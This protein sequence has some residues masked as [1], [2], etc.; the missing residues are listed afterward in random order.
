MRVLI[1]VLLSATLWG[2]GQGGTDSS[3][4]SAVEGDRGGPGATSAPTPAGVEEAFDAT[5]DHIAE[6]GADEAHSSATDYVRRIAQERLYQIEAAR[7]AM[8]GNVSSEMKAFAKQA[9]AVNM[10]AL[11]ALREA[12]RAGGHIGLVPGTVNREQARQLDEL[13]AAKGGRLQQLYRRLAESTLEGMV[14]RHDQ[15]KKNGKVSSLVKYA[16]DHGPIETR[17]LT[18]IRENMHISEAQ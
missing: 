8:K 4:E 7:I 5:R 10:V 2:C 18:R 6:T 14:Q 11:D 9:E 15:Y 12:A 3:T 13:R 16:V 1:S 17:Q